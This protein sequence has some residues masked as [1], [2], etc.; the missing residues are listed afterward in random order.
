VGD[1]DAVP[2]RA[3]LP[4]F[5]RSAGL[6]RIEA[7]PEPDLGDK[8]VV[9]QVGDFVGRRRELR[10]MLRDLRS[11]ERGGILVHGIGGVGKTTTQ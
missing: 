7:P 6:E 2:A 3:A 9:R 8:V 4:L 5:E 1:P 10:A 11:A